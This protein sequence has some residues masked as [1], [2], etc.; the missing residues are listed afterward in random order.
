MA[1]GPRVK[2]KLCGDVIQSLHR[3]DWKMCKCKSIFVDGGGDYLRTGWP[4][5][6]S[7][8]DCIEALK[9]ETK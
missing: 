4:D 6:K 8:E 3:H 7:R 1:S 2:C 5:G 9:E